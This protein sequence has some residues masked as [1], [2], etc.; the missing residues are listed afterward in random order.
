MTNNPQAFPDDLPEPEFNFCDTDEGDPMD[1][2]RDKLAGFI[3]VEMGINGAICEQIAD[4][5]LRLG[6]SRKTK[7][8]MVV[9]W[10]PD[11]HTD[12]TN[13]KGLIKLMH[14]NYNDGIRDCKAAF[15]K[16]RKEMG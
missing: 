11:K 12:R 4:L 2:E 3:A 5:V 9:S 13:P 15:D 16:A 8:E 6:Y 10:P 14:E 7:R 1:E